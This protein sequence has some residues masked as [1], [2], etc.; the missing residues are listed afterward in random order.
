MAEQ[1]RTAKHPACSVTGKAFFSNGQPAVG[2]AIEAID[3]DLTAEKS[4]GKSIVDARGFYK[5]SYEP[6][7]LSNAAKLSADLIVKLI[8]QQGLVLAASPLL[9]SAPAHAIVDLRSTVPVT[10]PPEYE[11]VL[12][13]VT[14][15]L[16]GLNLVDLTADQLKY[17][18]QV[19]GWKIEKIQR[20]ADSDRLRLTLADTSAGTLPG[21][22]YYAWLQQGLPEEPCALLRQTRV[23]LEDALSKAH[24]G[25]IISVPRPDQL[26]P[27][28]AA[29][30]AAADA[31]VTHSLTFI[32]EPPVWP[33][34][35]A[36]LVLLSRFERE[37]APSTEPAYLTVLDL[38]SAQNSPS[39]AADAP[40]TLASEKLHVLAELV[41]RDGPQSRPS[42]EELDAHGFSADERNLV[43]R[44]YALAE[45][46]QYHPP[47]IRDLNAMAPAS[48]DAIRSG[49]AYLAPLTL[50]D[51]RAKLDSTGMPPGITGKTEQ[52]RF[53][54]YAAMLEQGVE[55]AHRTAVLVSRIGQDR[56]AVPRDVKP[57]V[58]AFFA[59][60]A[61][62]SFE[63]HYVQSFLAESSSAKLDSVANPTALK[64][65]LLKLERTLKLTD[66]HRQH[67]V[68]L[69]KQFDSAQKISR[70]GKRNFV[71][72][73]G[74]HPDVGM[75]MSETIFARAEQT[76]AIALNI[77]MRY[78]NDGFNP[79]ALATPPL[80]VAG[81]VSANLVANSKTIPDLRTL[82]GSLDGNACDPNLSVLSPAAYFVDLMKFLE[83]SV[84]SQGYGY[85]LSDFPSTID[86][87]NADKHID[88]PQGLT[89]KNASKLGI[90]STIR[91]P[92][93]SFP[94]WVRYHVNLGFQHLY[95]F[96]DKTEANHPNI[97][98][99]PELRVF[100]S[101]D[102]SVQSGGINR[103]LHIA[104]ANVLTALKLAKQDGVKWFMHIDGDELLYSP[105]PI[106]NFL[107]Q[108]EAHGYAQAW[109][110]NHEA[111]AQDQDSLSPFH[112]RKI[113]KK[114]GK[115]PFQY[116]SEG[117]SI[118]QVDHISG[119]T[120]AHFFNVDGQTIRPK[121]QGN[122][123]TPCILHYPTPDFPRWLK[124]YK[125]LGSF[126]DYYWDK[127]EWKIHQTIYL[128][129]RDTFLKAQNTGDWE[130]ARKFF[131][132]TLL[133]SDEISGLINKGDAFTLN[134]N[135][136]L[137][138]QQ[139]AAGIGRQL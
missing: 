129:S 58:I 89:V 80:P 82:F 86:F 65:M 77:V 83:D 10:E 118:A 88:L 110:E 107:I 136:W 66:N 60:N 131:Q 12:A 16:R 122:I 98:S 22:V 134:L 111:I 81:A 112:D 2:C 133:T 5:I 29:R 41:S 104:N 21:G 34:L 18:S 125:E 11:R 120:W 137:L 47:L 51:W 84:I 57:D 44:T 8:D 115:V 70:V 93:T 20:L 63:T 97:P 38:F 36:D 127:P 61:G 50:E 68:L 59:N 46:T 92:D 13:A 99:C 27:S 31:I 106:N 105:T 7:Q 14:P 64:A 124:K 72:Q 37:L 87:F 90:V 45:L 79:P 96:L 40:A 121:G 95:V 42:A 24:S 73:V 33:A 62:F 55:S 32:A 85:G 69:A 30:R 25:N 138:G 116:H 56:V 94:D 6:A 128:K 17:L 126:V 53:N 91:D 139:P 108:L 114:F 43:L 74:P 49:L 35:A 102:I 19:S 113:F 103:L 135:P 1:K 123:A 101:A 130:I 52:D 71:Q 75:K 28:I 48:V 119:I 54:S 9:G 100:P 76:A 117:K 23:R 26:K 39:L 78:R 4:L 3:K 15:R 67:S 109:F 132:S